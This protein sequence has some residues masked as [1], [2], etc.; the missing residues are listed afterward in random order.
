VQSVLGHSLGAVKGWAAAELEPVYARARELCAQVRDPALG[1][2]I[3]LGQWV[4]RWWKLELDNAMELADELLA[5]AEDAK[6]PAMLL[7]ANWARGT[8]LFLL[9]EFIS[10]NEHLEK[11][12]TVFDLRQPLPSQLELRRV[13]SFGYLYLGLNQLGYPDRAW[14]KSLEM[15]EVAQRSSDPYVL[16]AASGF[17]AVHNLMRGDGPAAQKHA[18]KTMALIEAFGYRSLSELATMY[19]GAALIVQGRYEEGVAELRRGIS[20]F[21]ASAGTPYTWP[22]CF[23]AS[24]LARIGRPQEGLEVA[25][26]GFASAVKT[27]GQLHTPWLHQ[28]KGELLLVQNPSDV[29]EAELCFRTALEIARQR[30]ARSEELR[31]TT[32]LAGLLAKRGRR[33]EARAMLADIYGWFTEGFDT[34]DL[35]DAKALLDQLNA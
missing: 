26:E 12:L 7:S 4:M 33:D 2:P 31:A 11:A 35:K 32:S 5:I 1:F 27:G 3:L 23:L 24:G 14:V 25:E 8:I 15:M 20:A 13:S 28:V 30:S 10:A 19:H 22:F 6:D 9:G 16:T 17:A 34:R 21:R 29:A 18:E